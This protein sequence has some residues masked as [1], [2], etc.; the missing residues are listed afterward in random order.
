[1]KRP[2]IPFSCSVL[3][4]LMIAVTAYSQD[5]KFQT[6]LV[7]TEEVPA[8]STSGIATFKLEITDGIISYELKYAGLSSDITQAHIHFGQR[9]VNG[10]VSVFLCSNLPN[11]PQGIQGCPN[12]PAIIQGII[13]ASDIVGPA[14]Q[15]I[16]PGELSKLLEAMNVEVTYVNIHTTK[17]PN[18]EIRGQLLAVQEEDSCDFCECPECE[19]PECFG[20]PYGSCESCEGPSFRE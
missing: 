17:F 9:G 6:T 13:R 8:I 3:L 4:M 20:G 12:Q 19:C 7:G 2:L 11:P 18:G 14:Q 15:G 16:N 1:M 10:G 5:R